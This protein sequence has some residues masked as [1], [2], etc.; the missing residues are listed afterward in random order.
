MRRLG[1]LAFG[2]T[3]GLAVAAPPAV[4]QTVGALTAQL[5]SADG[6]RREEAAWLLATYGDASAIP[7]LSAALD[8]H[9]AGVRVT[10]AF[11]LSVMAPAETMRLWGG[12]LL[13]D[14]EPLI[15]EFVLRTLEGGY[16]PAADELLMRVAR[17]HPDPEIRM[18]ALLL[19]EKNFTP[20]MLPFFQS[21]AEGDDDLL[22]VKALPVLVKKR[23]FAEGDEL[24][25]L[26]VSFLG[27]SDP[28]VRREAVRGL[29]GVD[30]ERVLELL[31]E[32]AGDPDEGVRNAALAGCSRAVDRLSLPRLLEMYDAADGSGRASIAGFLPLDDWELVGPLVDKAVADPLPSPRRRVMRR[33]RKAGGESLRSYLE[34]GARD[35][36]PAVRIEAGRGLAAYSSGS[37][38]HLARLASDPSPEVREAVLEALTSRGDPETLNIFVGAAGK[39]EVQLR[40]LAVEGI[41]KCGS[42]GRVSAL[43]SLLDDGDAGVRAAAIHGLWRVAGDDAATH[44]ACRKALKDPAPEVRA[45][46]A[47]GLGYVRP[48]GWIE[49]VGGLLEDPSPIARRAAVAAL[50]GKWDKDLVR[51]LAPR[52]DDTD[53]RVR[54]SAADFFF[55]VPDASVVP[56]LRIL[57]DDPDFGVRNSAERALVEAK[58]IAPSER[59][60]YAGDPGELPQEFGILFDFYAQVPDTRM[61]SP[62]PALI[63]SFEYHEAITPGAV[64][65]YGKAFT[66]VIDDEG[67]LFLES[68][69]ERQELIPGGQFRRDLEWPSVRTLE[70][71]GARDGSLH[72]LVWGRQKGTEHRSIYTFKVAENGRDVIY[73]SVTETLTVSNPQIDALRSSISNPKRLQK[74]ME[75]MGLKEGPSRALT[76]MQEYLYR[77]SSQ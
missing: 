8:D 66:F 69:G 47:E 23:L 39:E 71:F 42:S 35:A 31:Q 51:F 63:G 49:S 73:S 21:I 13:S 77:R 28:T 30:D 57:W 41:V 6:H 53:A 18:R 29:R 52:L 32:A 9:E 46:A 56:K 58:A 38:E 5:E 1:C 22:K 72:R 74:M 40:L 36:D 50:G 7:A 12:L 2:A 27:H 3:I 24:L 65:G 26:F 61:G 17:S 43:G 19:L 37:V 60:S 70:F 33:F 54:Q 64:G 44:D 76:P 20:Q 55:H 68:W 15:H 16:D 34:E 10:A 48:K 11:T 14:E 25:P 62:D 75:Q 67:K 4:A 59:R 45:A